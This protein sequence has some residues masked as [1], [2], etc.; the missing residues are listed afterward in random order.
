MA[1]W[2]TNPIMEWSTDGGTTWFKVTDHGREAVQISVNRIGTDQRMANGTLRRYHVAKKRTF[3]TSWS[4]LPDKA[5]DFLANGQPGQWI[6]D[7]HETVDGAFHM[8]LRSGSDRDLTL[9]GLNGKVVQ[10]MITD[11]SR[12][13]NKRGVAFDLWDIDITLEEC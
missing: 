6:E 8:R 7:F 11:Y 1:S 4:N 13:T 2:K 10:V 9:T 12:N 3:T 5:T